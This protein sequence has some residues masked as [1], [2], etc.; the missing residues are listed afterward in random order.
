MQKQKV[1]K[2]WIIKNPHCKQTRYL[3]PLLAPW[4]KFQ[5]VA[6]A[7]PACRQA[8]EHH[9]NNYNQFFFSKCL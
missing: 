5:K 1:N 2:L 3:D 8:G 4:L 9:A 7:K 6:F